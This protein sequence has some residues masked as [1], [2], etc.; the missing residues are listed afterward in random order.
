MKC[1][2]WYPIAEQAATEAE[3]KEL[4]QKSRTWKE[5]K[6]VLSGQ[7]RQYMKEHHENSLKQKEL[8]QTIQQLRQQD[9][10]TKRVKDDNK[11]QVW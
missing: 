8:H 9:Q 1:G 2:C 3:L 10:E 11:Q 4:R 7:L 5:E 6:E